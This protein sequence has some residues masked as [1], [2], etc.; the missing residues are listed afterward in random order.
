LLN[1]VR[2]HFMMSVHSFC[3]KHLTRSS[4]PIC[5]YVDKTVY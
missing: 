2:V 4:C 5:E 1:A 3:S